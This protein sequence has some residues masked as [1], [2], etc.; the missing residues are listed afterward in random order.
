MTCRDCIWFKRCSLERRG[1]CT[2]FKLGDQQ[3]GQ[4]DRHTYK[5]G[6]VIEQTENHKQSKD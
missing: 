3:P 6:G 1:I 5:R 2:D 4:P